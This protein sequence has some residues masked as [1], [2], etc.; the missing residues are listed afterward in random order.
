MSQSPAFGPRRGSSPRGAAGAAARRNESQDYLLMDSELGEDGCPQAPLPC[1]GYYPCFRGSDNRLAHRRQTVLRE[2]G[3]R[4]ANRGPAYMFSDRS[5]SLSIEEERFL[6]AAEYGNI[7]VVRKMLEECHSLNVNCVDYMG[8]NALQLAVANEHLEITEL[9]LKKENLSRVGDALLLAISKGYVRIVE[10]ILSH[11]AFAEGKRLATSPSQSELQQDDF[12]AY[13]EDGT[14]FSH[15]VT[16]IILAAH[17]QEYE[18]VHTLLRKGARIERPHDYFC[19]CNDCNQ[20]Q[21]HDS[22]SHSRSRINAYKGLAS[23]A[24]L[25]L[26]SEDPVMTALELSNELAVLANIEKE[27]KMG[28]IMRGPFMKFVAHAASFTIFLGLLVMNAAD[29]FEGTKLLPN[30]TSTDNAKQLFRMKTSCFSWMEML[31]ISW[32][33]GMIWAECKEIWTQG[34]KEYLFE[35]WN[36]L[37]FGMLAIFAASFI[38]RFMAFWHASKAQSIIDANDT[39]KDLTKVTLGDNVKYYNLARIKW[40][41]SDPQIISEGLYAIA[42]VLS[43]SRIAYILPANES[44]GPLQISLGR[45]VKDIFKFMVIFIMVFVAFM[46]GM[47]NLYSYYIG[48][49]QNEAFTTVE[50]SFKTL[51]WAIFGLSEV[52]SVVINYNHKFIENIGY[53]L[54][55]VYNVTMVI[56]LLNMLIAMINSSFQEIEDDADVEW[57]FA[58]AKLW[59]SYFEE[60][61]TLP[62][63]FNLVP[64]PK[65]LFYLLLKLKKWISELFQ[66]HK[67]GFQEDAEM[68]KINEEKKL[69]ILGSHEDLSKLSL[70]KK[71]VGHNKQPSIRSSEDFHLN[72]FN[73]PPRQ[74]QKIMK[75]LIKR[76]V[77]QAQIDKESDEV[78]EGELKEIKQDISSL[79]YELLEEKSQNTED[80]AEL[81]RELGEKLSME[82]NQEETNR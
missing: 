74:Y 42:V 41:P 27:F 79:R 45:T 17:C 23:P 34:P 61:R 58:R 26:S 67:K 9:L 77:L 29:R 71:Q 73:N 51:F 52:K 4:L 14:R 53:V 66:G 13:D 11:P 19:K 47:F 68:N 48:A 36:M 32:V 59:F 20:K 35:L 57:K 82:P 16:P 62:V 56:V 5:T 30:E 65:S 22:F 21:K 6:D 25:S 8:Q 49:K 33:I 40:D 69:G 1:Y 31:I 38:A 50:E 64:S 18:I 46:I 2:K 10:A 37:D 55:G 78:N 72:S 28:K 76:Y 80:L 44:F 75:R 43:F 54:Y 81:I 24:Y 7:P 63:P 12:Y 70:D 15:D 39:L 3:R 60:G